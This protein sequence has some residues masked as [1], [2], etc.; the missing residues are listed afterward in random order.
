MTER[1]YTL[2]ADSEEA[3]RAQAR[4]RAADEHGVPADS[5]EVVSAAK[6]EDSGGVIG[7]R[8][9]VRVEGN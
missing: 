4:R 1:T 9:T 5:V 6:L 2:Q 7:Y 8:V 3:A